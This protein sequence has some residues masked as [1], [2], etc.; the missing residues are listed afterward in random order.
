[1]LSNRLAKAALSEQLGDSD[2]APSAKLPVLYERWALGGSGLVITG[3]V[4]I[5]HHHLGEPRNVVVED[6]RDLDALRAWALAGAVAA[7]ENGSQLWM[8]INHPGR[9]TPRFLDPHPVA[10]SAV[11]V[12]LGGLFATP[13]ALTIAEVE[14]LV[15]RYASTARIAQQAGF[16]GVQLH[17]AHGY[18][19]S[20][21]LSPVANIRTDEWGGDELGRM[22]FVLEV[23]KAVRAAVGPSFPIG[24]KLNSADF[25]RGGMDVDASMRVAASVSAAGIDLL[26]V[27]G[28]TYERPAM[29]GNQ[30]SSTQE[31]EA[32]F[33][34]YA[35]QVRSVLGGVPL[36]LTG[37]FRAASAMREA[38]A[39][40]DVDVVG[41]GRPLTV[42]P[43]LPARI[44][45]GDSAGSE[46]QSK[47][48]ISRQLSGLA[49]IQWHERQM[50]RLAS[51]KDPDP[52]QSLTRTMAASL[53]RD[54]FR[55]LRKL[56]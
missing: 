11:P 15:A 31:R 47:R 34:D 43:D 12:R 38:V 24:L 53:L 22:R 3:N 48:F 5:D 27:S 21:F 44:L 9:Q 42:E 54:G 10:P 29:M 25:Q 6:D 4:M 55:S 13:R 39:S 45:S 56:R 2:H 49:E 18:L 51:G 28:G 40:G 14:G 32:Y 20:Q 17:G 7:E 23:I 41:L 30:R 52:H 33:I 26:E 46:L 50:H 35:R 1:V 16:S 8:Q 36:M 19:I 37:G